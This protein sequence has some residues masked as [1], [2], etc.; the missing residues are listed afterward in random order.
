MT[1]LAP[2]RGALWSRAEGDDVVSSTKRKAPAILT[3]LT[4]ILVAVALASVKNA[5]ADPNV[6]AKQAQAQ[7]VLEQ[8]QT[9]DGQLSHAIESYNLANVKLDAIN[10]DL[11]ANARHLTVAKSSLRSAQTHLSAR[12][13]SLYVNGSQGNALEVAARRGVAR[14]P[15]QPDGRGRAG[16]GP[17][18]ARAA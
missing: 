15:A 12:L 3:F 18:R 8:I 5:S 16:V 9:I 13:V 1:D 6:D 10:A 2:H 14:R 17:G 7:D 11:K 4:A